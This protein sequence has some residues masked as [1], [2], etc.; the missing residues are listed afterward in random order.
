MG[1]ARGPFGD[2]GP[3]AGK[4][5]ALVGPYTIGR[6]DGTAGRQQDAGHVEVSEGSGQAGEQKQCETTHEFPSQG[7]RER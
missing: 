2:V 1:G 3:T 4:E 7:M 6:R 5:Q